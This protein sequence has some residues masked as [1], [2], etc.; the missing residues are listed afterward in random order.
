MDTHAFKPFVAMY[1]IAAQ[2]IFTRNFGLLAVTVIG[3]SA[4]ATPQPPVAKA[5]YDFGATTWPSPSA[6]PSAAPQLPALALAEVEAASALDSP[7]V[8]Y[9]LAYA[10][11]YQLR[12][13]TLAR[14]SMPPAR[15]LQQRL[16]EALRAERAV[17][18]ADQGGA[19]LQLRVELQEFSQWFDS[20]ASSSGVLRLQATLLRGGKLVAQR[21]FSASS[22]APSTD[23]AGGVR[24]LAQASD[25][26]VGQIRTW[27]NAQPTAP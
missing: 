1:S 23:A 27:L 26:A 19:P 12:S 21:S 3:L 5:V 8:T 2:A 25:D 20:P 9:R 7:A 16:G 10:D 4:C 13:Y 6:A 15:L 22:A 14:W 24:A 11:R 17:L 18:S